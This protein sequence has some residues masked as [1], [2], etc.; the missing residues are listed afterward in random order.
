MCAAPSAGAAP[1]APHQANR[2]EVEK[3]LSLLNKTLPTGQR[4]YVSIFGR[5]KMAV[6]KT[7]TPD[8]SWVSLHALW[9]ADVN[10][11]GV[12]EYFW[13]SEGEGAAHYDYFDIYQLRG[14][15]LVELEFPLNS[16]HMPSN[17]DSPPIEQDARGITYLQLENIWAEDEKGKKIYEGAN[18]NAAPGLACLVIVKQEYRWDSTG[19]VIVYQQT[20]R[21]T[22]DIDRLE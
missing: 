14:G 21:T 8:G 12:A 11:D 19:L 3:F 2:A 17:L 5:D 20:E 16:A 18:S 10:N 15:K 13:T 22:Y 4:Q 7:V 6:V 1:I 9:I